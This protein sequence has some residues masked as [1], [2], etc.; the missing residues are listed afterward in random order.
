MERI[1]KC[2]KPIKYFDIWSYRL[3][4]FIF[5]RLFLFLSFPTQRFEAAAKAGPS[6]SPVP[7]PAPARGSVASSLSA[8]PV[9]GSVANLPP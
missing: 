9:F 7:A 4:L 8:S 2:A 3:N 5:L 6:P 1:A